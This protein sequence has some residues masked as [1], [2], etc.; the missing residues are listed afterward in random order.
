MR[1]RASERVKTGQESQP[2]YRQASSGSRE[3]DE[4][5]TTS[6][7]THCIS[8]FPSTPG[9]SQSDPPT[10]RSLR[11]RVAV[12]SAVDHKVAPD[13]TISPDQENSQHDKYLFFF[14][15]VVVVLSQSVLMQVLSIQCLFRN[16]KKYPSLSRLLSRLTQAQI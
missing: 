16:V 14:V 4:S 1:R 12:D 2:S 7:Q 8:P 6:S 10:R 13:T 11:K 15:I 9:S 3:S 5:P